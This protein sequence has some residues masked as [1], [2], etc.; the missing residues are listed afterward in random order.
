MAKARSAGKTVVGASTAK[1]K[2]T[3][4]ARPKAAGAR[5]M[6]D[7]ASGKKVFAKEFK[8][9]KAAA[10]NSDKSKLSEAKATARAQ[11]KGMDSGKIKAKPGQKSFLRGFLSAKGG[12][13]GG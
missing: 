11:L 13:G 10:K 3:G 7:K 5:Q 8:S 12:G 9:G 2:G 6:K 1:A 4:F